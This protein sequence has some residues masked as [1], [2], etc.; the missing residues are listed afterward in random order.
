MRSALRA[1]AAPMPV[2][3]S[4][5]APRLGPTRAHAASSCRFIR[6]ITAG[7]SRQAGGQMRAIGEAGRQGGGAGQLGRCGVVGSMWRGRELS[8]VRVWQIGRAFGLPHNGME[9]V[10]AWGLPCTT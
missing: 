9:G 4:S 2:D 7:S 3:S 8:G 10:W 6:R 5:S 1:S